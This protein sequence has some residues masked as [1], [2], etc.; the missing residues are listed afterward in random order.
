VTSPPGLERRIEIL[1]RRPTHSPHNHEVRAVVRLRAHDACEYCLLPTINTFH[2]EHII[3]PALWEDYAR[4]RLPGV[5]PRLGRHG[6]DH[7]DNYAWSC[8]L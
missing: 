4:G 5:P 3:P 8:S 6:P 1:L 2:I 7:I